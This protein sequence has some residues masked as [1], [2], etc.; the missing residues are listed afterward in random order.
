[1]ELG[2]WLP[3][4]E[5]TRD[6]LALRPEKQTVIEHDYQLTPTYQAWT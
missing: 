5:A 4:D 6:K 3:K 1:V 2:Y